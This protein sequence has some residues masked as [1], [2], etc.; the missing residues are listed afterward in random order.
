MLVFVYHSVPTC[1]DINT[2]SIWEG[3]CIILQLSGIYMRIFM[4]GISLPEGS[5]FLKSKICSEHQFSY[6]YTEVIKANLCFKSR[7]YYSETLWA[8]SLSKKYFYALIT[9]HGHKNC[10]RN[11]SKGSRKP[12]CGHK[13][14]I[15]QSFE[16]HPALFPQPPHY[17]IF[18]HTTNASQPCSQ[19]L[20]Q[21][22]FISCP[23]QLYF[24]YVFDCKP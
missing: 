12:L 18:F 4:H 16:N 14:K 1:L 22:S 11:L 8:L 20:H 15:S 23:W 21:G 2:Q 7:G 19:L 13:N 3:F 10:P 5:I 6:I 24:F 17:F 9:T